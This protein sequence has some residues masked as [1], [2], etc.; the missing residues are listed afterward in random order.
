MEQDNGTTVRS[1][2]KGKN[3]PKMKEYQVKWCFGGISDKLK[4]IGIYTTII[5][6]ILE[7][8]AGLSPFSPTTTENLPVPRIA[9]R[10]N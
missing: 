8:H 6:N 5:A 9:P 2:N 4:A 3:G 10:P 1:G 7:A